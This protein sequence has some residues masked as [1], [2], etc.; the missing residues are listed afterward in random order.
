MDNIELGNLIKSVR[1]N[2]LRM[3]QLQFM[4]R[5]ENGYQENLPVGMWLPVS[6]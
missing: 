4:K 1:K 2:E 3:T 6:R 5:T